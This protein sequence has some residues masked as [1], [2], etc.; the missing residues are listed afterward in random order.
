MPAAVLL[1]RALGLTVA[2]PL[3]LAR[4]RRRCPSQRCCT[5]V[6]VG[7][8]GDGKRRKFQRMGRA[9]EGIMAKGT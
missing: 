9:G 8:G 2:A 3:K 6:S 7:G 1:L 4:Q 5:C